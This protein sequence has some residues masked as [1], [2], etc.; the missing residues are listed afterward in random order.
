MPELGVFE[1][2]LGISETVSAS[3]IGS[4]DGSVAANGI[5]GLYNSGYPP[6]FAIFCCSSMS[7]WFNWLHG[8]STEFLMSS[9]SSVAD[10]RVP[11]FP[12]LLQFLNKHSRNHVLHTSVRSRE[13]INCAR[14]QNLPVSD[15]LKQLSNFLPNRVTLKL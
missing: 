2:T 9:L 3:I 5:G 7:Y 10:V 15:P 13:I 11:Q 4:K 6:Y 14:S 12:I 1:W 8:K